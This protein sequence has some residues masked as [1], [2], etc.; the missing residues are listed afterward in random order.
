LFCQR[1]ETGLKSAEYSSLLLKSRNRDIV[2][3]EGAIMP[4]HCP[5]PVE[6]SD[7]RCCYRAG[8]APGFTLSLLLI[9]V[10]AGYAGFSEAAPLSTPDAATA[11]PARTQEGDTAR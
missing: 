11:E 2:Q 6:F 4:R 5:V 1:G 8:S 7:T 3:A 9:A 10:L